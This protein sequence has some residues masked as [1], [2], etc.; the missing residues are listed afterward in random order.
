MTSTESARPWEV[1]RRGLLL[2]ISSPSGAG[3]T[4]LSRRLVS[5]HD[6]LVLSISATT[7]APR[8]GEAEG[9]EYYFVSPEQFDEMVAGGRLL[10]WAHVHNHRYGTPRAPVEAALA[11]G[12]DVLFDIDWQG[13]AEIR[14]VLP[15]DSVSVFV[16][17][18][19]W[20]DLARRLHARA[21]DAEAVIQQRLERGR[22]EITHWGDYDYIIVNKNFDRAFADLGH[23]YR[24]ER[25]KPARNPWLPDFVRGLGSESP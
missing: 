12:R 22:E 9:R 5:D 19:S 8:P 24:A 16:L 14:K 25:M 1:Q 10:E 20:A 3:K 2:L 18:P 11:E 13:A 23:I 21:Q 17:P 7:R 15:D 4:S 6:D